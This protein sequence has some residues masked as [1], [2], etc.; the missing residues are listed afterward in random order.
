MIHVSY[1]PHIAFQ[2][3]EDKGLT[4][5]S[6]HYKE[7]CSSALVFPALINS[8]NHVHR[9][10]SKDSTYM[11]SPPS[12]LLICNSLAKLRICHNCAKTLLTL[13][14]QKIGYFKNSTATALTMCF[15]VVPKSQEDN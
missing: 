10:A 9:L 14:F 1:I 11:P 3:P 5:N 6:S 13:N 8:S 2:L 4:R 12:G 7:W 15:F